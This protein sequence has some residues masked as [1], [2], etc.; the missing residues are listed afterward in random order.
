MKVG[1]GS[2]G[3]VFSFFFKKVMS[4]FFYVIA[5][6]LVIIWSIGVYVYSAGSMIHL[7]IVFT[8]LAIVLRILGGHKEV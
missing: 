4:S 3:I 1:K 7:L 8:I 6:L 5:A 2:N